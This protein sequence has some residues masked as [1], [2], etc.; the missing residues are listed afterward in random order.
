NQ[1]RDNALET[2][3]LSILALLTTA[4]AGVSDPTSIAAELVI[5]FLVYLPSFSFLLSAIV[6]RCSRWR[7]NKMLRIQ[8]RPTAALAASASVN[9]MDQVNLAISPRSR[10]AQTS[11]DA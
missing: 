8:P 11:T 5:S 10:Q 4:L 3:S 9:S 1:S 6:S 7:Q 2:I